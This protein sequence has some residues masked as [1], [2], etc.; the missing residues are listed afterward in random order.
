MDNHALYREEI[1]EHYRHPQNF[2]KLKN[3]SR[4]AR[5][6]NPLCGDEIFLQITFDKKG[7][8]KE[9][10]FS[11]SGCALSI[12]S[13]SLFTEYLRGKT[14]QALKNIPAHKPERLLA[15]S[16]G[17]ARKKCVQLPHA[18]L[19]KLLTRKHD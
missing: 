2:G 19:K 3:N 8:V 16:V 13:A 10:K 1:L 18:A 7:K 14:R 4:S 12:A 17:A 15:V 11:G 6:L 9:I 5:V